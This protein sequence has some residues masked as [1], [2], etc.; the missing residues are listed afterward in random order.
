MPLNR[1]LMGP[2]WNGQPLSHSA[3]GRGDSRDSPCERTCLLRLLLF[4][5]TLLQ[6]LH[7]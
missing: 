2:A 1:W 3:D 5:K 4:W 7:W 6:V